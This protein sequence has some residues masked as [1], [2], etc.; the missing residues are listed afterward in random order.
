[1]EDKQLAGD[2]YSV[3]RSAPDRWEV[4][5]SGFAKVIASFSDRNDA[6]DYAQFLADL[7][8]PAEVTVKD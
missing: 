8:G 7:Q 2:H 5:K 3:E 6:V 4:S 1:M